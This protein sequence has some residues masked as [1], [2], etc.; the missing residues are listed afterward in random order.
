VGGLARA[1]DIPLLAAEGTKNHVHLLISLPST[2]TVAEIMQTFKGNT[3][4]WINETLG[5]FAWQEGYGAFSV[6][7]SQGTRVILYID[8]QEE[9]H[10]KWSFQE[11]FVSLLQKYGVPYDPR[12]ALG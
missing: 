4:H 2:R 7:Q 3:S 12:Y 11:E 8:G 5:A 10:K 9:H 6:S 1:K